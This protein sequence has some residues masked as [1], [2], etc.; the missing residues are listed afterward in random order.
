MSKEAYYFSHDSNAR[1]DAK[2]VKLRRKLG[3]EGYGIYFCIVEM[4][5]EDSSFKLQTSS[6]ED[7]SFS[8]NVPI[9]KVKSVVTEF[10][11]FVIEDDYFYSPRLTRSMQK[12]NE[13]KT[14]RV[15]AGKKG[16]QAM[17][18][19]NS[20][21]AQAKVEQG[22][23]TP[24]ANLEQDDKQS[25]SIP[26]ALKERKGKEIKGNERKEKKVV[27]PPT[28]DEVISFFNSE[29][30]SESSARKAWNHYNDGDWFDSNGK[31]VIIWKSKMR[32]VWFREEHKQPVKD[33]IE[34]YRHL[35]YFKEYLHSVEGYT[36]RVD[37]DKIIYTPPR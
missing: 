32:N 36:W 14:K 8:I 35:K 22:L 28:I 9:E 33:D 2:I 15:E 21:N 19:Q 18:K 16:G 27:V 11:L 31:K 37:G 10:D 5:R 3:L 13:L 24:Q 30:Y 4:L 26:Q 25:L 17:L 6:F 1:N 12:Y 34:K 20:S 29:G 7:I 23:S